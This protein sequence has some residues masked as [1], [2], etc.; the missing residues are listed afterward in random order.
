MWVFHDAVH[1]GGV[2][3]GSGSVAW[4]YNY[5]D[6]DIDMCIYIYI[7]TYIYMLYIY[8]YVLIYIYIYVYR[9][10]PKVRIRKGGDPS[11]RNTFRWYLKP[12]LII[13]SPFW[14][15]KDGQTQPPMY[16]LRGVEYGKYVLLLV[17][18]LVIG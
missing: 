6:I 8:I 1:G 16:F 3:R 11:K 10:P 2:R 13:I 18:R 5:I 17:I 9:R 4:E 7:Y 12:V 15:S 14:A